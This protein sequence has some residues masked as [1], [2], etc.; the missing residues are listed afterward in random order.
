MKRAICCGAL[1]LAGL[2]SSAC[3][4]GTWV[5]FPMAACA[6]IPQ[7]KT[8]E[9]AQYIARGVCSNVGKAFT[10]DVRCEKKAVQIKC[11]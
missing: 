9:N 6:D 11:E 7:F 3:K 4:R 2:S 1:V 5:D 10:G 8:A